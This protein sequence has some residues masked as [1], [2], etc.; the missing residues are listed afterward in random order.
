[1]IFC[2]DVETSGLWD[3]KAPD[4]AGHQPRLVRVAAAIFDTYDREI[5]CIDLTVRPEGFTIPEAATKVHGITQTRAVEIGVPLR[6]AMSLV[7]HMAAAC[8]TIVGHGIDY[9]L[10]LLNAELARLN[11]TRTLPNPN[12][13]VFCTMK[14][15]TTWC[16]ILHANPKGPDDYKW[17][18]LSEACVKLLK[19]PTMPHDAM[20]DMRT[21]FKLY[22]WLTSSAAA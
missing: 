21:A 8:P 3:D 7:V 20:W 9:D 1:M 17:P 18:T 19:Q 10:R 15:S 11:V 5:S 16:Q 2:V 4:T 22:R 14:R 12:T 13:E 6:T